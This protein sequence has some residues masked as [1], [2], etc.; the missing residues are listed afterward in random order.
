MLPSCRTHIRRNVDVRKRWA[1]GP[2]APP[3]SAA[4]APSLF[5]LPESPCSIVFYG[6]TYESCAAREKAARMSPRAAQVE[7]HAGAEEREEREAGGEEGGRV[8]WPRAASSFRAALFVL[9]GES[10]MKSVQCACISHGYII[11]LIFAKM[12]L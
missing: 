12:P 3:E 10:R 2:L 6:G 11:V 5:P 9:Y 1:K 4:L 8:A 7:L